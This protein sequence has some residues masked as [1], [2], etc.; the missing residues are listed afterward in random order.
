M[1]EI[2]SLIRI[3]NKNLLVDIF[4][5]GGGKM[6]SIYNKK[7]GYE[8]L[9]RNEA[10]DLKTYEPGSEYDPVFYGGVDELLPNDVPEN[11]DGME[12]PD[13]G[14]LWTQSLT[15]SIKNDCLTLQGFLPVSKLS[16]QKSIRLDE[17]GPFIHTDYAITN[18]NTLAVKFLWKLHAALKIRKG[19]RM[20][21]RADKG[22]VVD[23]L[24]SRFKQTA[25]FQW[26]V[27]EKTDVSVIPEKNGTMD[28]FYIYE[29]EDGEVG[30]VNEE[31]AYFGYRFDKLV[32]P[33]VWLFA[34][35]GGFLDHY[36]AI[37]EPCTTM[38][39]SVNDAARLGQTMILQPGETVNTRVT[40]IAGSYL[41]YKINNKP[42][43]NR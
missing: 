32:F 41:D 2:S 14:E 6:T 33:Y 35:Y 40:I 3:E 38:P 42:N 13:H 5:G 24:Y 27:I 15:A 22:R 31:H 37:L 25:P 18:E 4:P 10:L 36:T 11:V 7:S 30:I 21:C 39:V 29:L 9:W 8:F 23:P 28:F 17:D 34:S 43:E 16:Y 12:F 20:I 19:D 1:M 26:P